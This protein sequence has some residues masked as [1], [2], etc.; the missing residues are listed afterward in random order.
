[1]KDYSPKR[2]FFKILF[3]YGVK[4]NYMF[5][6]LNKQEKQHIEYPFVV[7]KKYLNSAYYVMKNCKRSWKKSQKVRIWK[8]QRG[9]S[10]HVTKKFNLGLFQG[11]F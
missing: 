7:L 3:H 2:H 5:T 4:F 11:L 6:S 1:M 9:T 10:N 8:G